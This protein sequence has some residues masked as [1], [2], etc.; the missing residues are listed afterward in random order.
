MGTLDGSGGYRV[1]FDDRRSA[2]INVSCHDERGPHYM[3]PGNAEAV[4]SSLEAAVPV[5]S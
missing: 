1:E 2:H 5:G 4:R 3:F